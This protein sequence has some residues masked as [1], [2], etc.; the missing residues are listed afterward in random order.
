MRRLALICGTFLMTLAPVF[1]DGA[2]TEADRAKVLAALAR[3]GCTGGTIDVDDG[4]F[5][6]DDAICRD[7]HTYDLKFDPAFKLID[8]DLE[9]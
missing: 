3:E 6:V 2:I 4:I 7:G 8:K 9:R 1:A 5:E